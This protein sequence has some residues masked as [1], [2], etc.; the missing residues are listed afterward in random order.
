MFIELFCIFV[1]RLM[2][3]IRTEYRVDLLQFSLQRGLGLFWWFRH[4][5]PVGRIAKFEILHTLI[6]EVPTPNIDVRCF[7]VSDNANSA[8]DHSQQG[9]VSRCCLN[10]TPFHFI[11]PYFTTRVSS[12]VR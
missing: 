2:R 6:G 11:A 5:H 12:P 10:R 3:V 8:F 9:G 4:R 1:F 7:A